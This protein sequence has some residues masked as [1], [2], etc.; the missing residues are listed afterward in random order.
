MWISTILLETVKNAR[1]LGNMAIPEF[2]TKKEAFLTNVNIK[3]CLLWLTGIRR[4]E[5]ELKM[6]YYSV[7]SFEKCPLIWKNGHTNIRCKEMNKII[8]PTLIS[9]LYILHQ[10][11]NS[12][13]FL[14][15]YII[16]IIIII[17]IRRRHLVSTDWWKYFCF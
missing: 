7:K 17:I 10:Q 15:F 8:C 6:E 14:F 2:H 16:I 3:F 12:I 1:Y 9:S 13:F 4:Q 11:Q 5:N